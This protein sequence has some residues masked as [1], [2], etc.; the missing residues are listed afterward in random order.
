MESEDEKGKKQRYIDLTKAVRKE[1]KS[2]PEP[3]RDQCLVALANISLGLDPGLTVAPLS[4]TVGK[5]VLEL[6][7][8]GRPAYR[9]VYTLNFPGKVVVLAARTKTS[10]GV[11]KQLIEVAASRLKAYG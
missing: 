1:L 10:N 7:I 11:D 4:N 5:G 2:F 9:V 3:I 6:K 8:N